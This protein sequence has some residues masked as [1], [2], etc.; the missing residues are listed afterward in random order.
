LPTSAQLRYASE[1]GVYT[2]AFT[3]PKKQGKAHYFLDLGQVYFTTEV[4]VNGQSAGQRLYAPYQLDITPF[5]RKGRNQV[6]V[7]VTPTQLNGFISKGL[8]QDKKY[9]QFKK[10]GETLMSEGLVGPV[11][12]TMKPPAN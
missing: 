1:P 3:L 10:K 9:A 11:M 12:V 5:V 7:R 4:R 2:S 8:A 6:E